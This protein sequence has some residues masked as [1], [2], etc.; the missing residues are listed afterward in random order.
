MNAIAT[1][2]RASM[3]YR[4]QLLEPDVREVVLAGAISFADLDGL[5]EILRLAREPG[6]RCLRLDLMGIAGIDSSAIGI[7]LLIRDAIA[8]RG[9]NLDVASKD[10]HLRD[11]LAVV[12]GKRAAWSKPVPSC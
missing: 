7:L 1:S 8:A 9:T 11:L 10:D 3:S 4:T 6:L 5:Q 2:K 12:R